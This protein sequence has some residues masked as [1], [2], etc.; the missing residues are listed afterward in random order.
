MAC[1]K[2]NLTPDMK[3]FGENARASDGLHKEKHLV[4][5]FDPY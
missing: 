5:E 4:S 3:D 2:L 1:G